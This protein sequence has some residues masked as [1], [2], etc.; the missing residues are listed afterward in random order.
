MKKVLFSSIL[1]IAL[2][3]SLI[4]GS[5]FALFTDEQEYTIEATA[6][7][8]DF[9]ATIDD[10]I[11][12]SRDIAQT[13]TFANGGTAVFTGNTLT[14]TN[15][16]PGDKV[17]FDIELENKSN[18]DIKYYLNWTAT[19]DLMSGTTPLVI[20]AVDSVDGV[21][22]NLGDADYTAWAANAPKER[23]LTVTV[24]LPEVAGNEYQEDTATI[25]FTVFAVQGNG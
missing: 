14:L 22:S 16:T 4:A 25:N 11:L 18:V 10:Q 19:G 9:V 7:K 8:V 21:V 20:S 6:A 23:T 17:V 3:L 5:T 2:C 13:N 24:E 1:T 15:I 12:Y